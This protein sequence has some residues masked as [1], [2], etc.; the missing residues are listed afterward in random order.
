[1]YANVIHFQLLTNYIFRLLLCS[2]MCPNYHFQLI[3]PSL[4]CVCLHIMTLSAQV[5]LDHI[6]RDLRRIKTFLAAKNGCLDWLGTTTLY[7]WK[8][9][10]KVMIFFSE[11]VGTHKKIVIWN[12][13]LTHWRRSVEPW[14]QLLNYSKS[15]FHFERRTCLT[16]IPEKYLSGWDTET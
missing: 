15:T 1:M 12:I 2:D 14:N 13:W 6:L 3:I 9:I 5:I 8:C 10:I 16:S 4:A 7:W 11:Q